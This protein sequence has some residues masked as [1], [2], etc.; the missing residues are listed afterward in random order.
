MLENPKAVNDYRKGKLK[1]LKF[2]IGKIAVK[3]D[4]KA[5]L[6]LVSKKFEELLKQ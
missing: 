4:E 5:N 3:T 2:L 6:A 1:V